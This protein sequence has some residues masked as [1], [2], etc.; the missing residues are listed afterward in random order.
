MFGEPSSVF[1][2]VFKVTFLGVLPTFV[3]VRMVYLDW[4]ESQSH[5]AS[6]KLDEDMGK[7]EEV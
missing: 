6:P 1:E 4:K 3:L 7:H 2:I 5:K